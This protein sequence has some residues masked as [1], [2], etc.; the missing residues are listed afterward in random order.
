MSTWCISLYV[1]VDLH[2]LS[3]LSARSLIMFSRVSRYC[4]HLAKSLPVYKH[5]QSPYVDDILHRGLD[6]TYCNLYDYNLIL[7]NVV[8]VYMNDTDYLMTRYSTLRNATRRATPIVIGVNKF[9]KKIDY[10][11]NSES[12][13]LIDVHANLYNENLVTIVDDYSIILYA[14]KCGDIYLVKHIYDLF[15]EKQQNN[16]D[17]DKI[18]YD[19]VMSTMQQVMRIA[20]AHN[21]ICI[22]EWLY[23]VLNLCPDFINLEYYVNLVHGEYIKNSNV[24]IWLI[25]N[26]Y[27]GN[28]DNTDVL[29]FVWSIVKFKYFRNLISLTKY[30]TIYDLVARHRQIL[31]ART[32]FNFSIQIRNGYNIINRKRLLRCIQKKCIILCQL[33][34]IWN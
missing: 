16:K 29:I 21:H 23:N 32:A 31:D 25:T 2:I 20:I 9:D 1:D 22:V 26:G 24:F 13:E 30:S 14:T 4:Q 27:Y 7:Y 8:D 15:I 5:I 28:S 34:I 10:A 6:N 33:Q 19:Y 18:V 12:H 17:K 3:F 11:Y